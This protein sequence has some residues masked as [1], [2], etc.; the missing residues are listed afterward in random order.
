MKKHLLFPVLA[1]GLTLL[2]VAGAKAFET[3]QGV[4]ATPITSLPFTITASGNYY[5][6]AN[7]STAN[8][9]AA[10]IVIAA[11]EVVLDLNGRTLSSTV[12]T[13]FNF[14]VFVFNQVDVTIQ[15]G[16][17]DGF[18][19]GV[20]FA[21]N[22][23]DNNAKNV[24]DNIRFNNDTIG[25]LSI[26]GQSNLVK[27]CIIDG[28]DIGIW[29]LSDLGG[30]RASNNILEA[31]KVTERVGAG[32]ALLSSSSGGVVFDN[33]VVSKGGSSVGMA[34]SGTDKYRFDSFVGFPKLSP[35]VG[36][37]NELADSL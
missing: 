23:T 12:D 35:H 29:F 6:P 11:S 8:P 24:A 5:L 20:Y 25:V 14:G 21:P 32:I 3:A 4:V 13:G 31:Q 30:S 17:I 10:A 15:N 33:N 16:D 18:Y 28:G 34:M 36:G 19:I 27:N 7:L 37:T 22:S 1:A 26:S 9:A 2:S